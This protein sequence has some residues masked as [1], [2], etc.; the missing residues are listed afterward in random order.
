MGE[1]RRIGRL[2]CCGECAYGRRF[3]CSTKRQASSMTVRPAARAFS[4]EAACVM[5]CW[6]QR[7][8]APMAMAE[9]ATGG[10]SSERRKT[11]TMSTGS[12]MSSRRAQ[13]LTPRT[14]DSLGLTGM[15]L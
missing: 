1:R 10:T 6:S 7:T 5:P 11:S 14:S 3:L 8:L 4:A 9:S 2:F 15:I 13:D 12:R